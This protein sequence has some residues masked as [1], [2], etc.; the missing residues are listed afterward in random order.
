LFLK[1]SNIEEILIKMFIKYNMYEAKQHRMVAYANDWLHKYLEEPNL[2]LVDQLKFKSAHGESSVWFLGHHPEIRSSGKYK[3]YPKLIDNR[4]C[5]VDMTIKNHLLSIEQNILKR[6]V[7]VLGEKGLKSV[8]TFTERAL[9]RYNNQFRCDAPIK[10]V[11]I[12]ESPEMVDEVQKE[13][14]VNLMNQLL[15]EQPVDLNKLSNFGKSRTIRL[16]LICP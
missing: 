6:E 3:R 15:P 2:K 14:P 1:N 10:R 4:D 11:K 8:L 16:D 12:D 7:K 9:K 5:Y 13:Q